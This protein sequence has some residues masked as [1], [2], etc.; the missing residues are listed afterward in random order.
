[1]VWAFGRTVGIWPDGL[2]GRSVGDAQ[3]RQPLARVGEVRGRCTRCSRIAGWSARAYDPGTAR[4][5][6]YGAAP[7]APRP[8]RGSATWPSASIEKQY[9]PSA[10]PVGRDSIRV[11][12]TPRTAN[13]S[14][15]SSSAPG[16]L[17]RMNTT[18]DVLSA[19][20]AGAGW[21]GR[22]TSTNRVTA[23]S[24]VGDTRRQRGQPVGRGGDRRRDRRVVRRALSAATIGGRVRRRR[25]VH[26]VGVGQVRRQPATALGR[27]VRVGR[28]ALGLTSASVVPARASSANCTSTR[29]SRVIISG[30][31]VASSSSVAATPPSTEFSSGTTAPSASPARTASSA[32][33]HRRVR[34]QVS[35]AARRAAT[36][37][38]AR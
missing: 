23:P 32:V 30:S 19:P 3:P 5:R 27:R 10:E 18:S 25:L 34:Q 28:D 22:D 29:S 38:P 16:W 36:A 21:P 31:P 6:R 37:A 8:T 7:S 24:L 35:A 20:V 17:S 13:C 4:P 33:A 1:M 9:L 15:S 14:S 11:R 12:S 2:G 26:D